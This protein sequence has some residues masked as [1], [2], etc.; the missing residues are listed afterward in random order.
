M[1]TK[2]KFKTIA[3]QNYPLNNSR[4]S[5]ENLYVYILFQTLLLLSN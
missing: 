3:Y 2:L 4:R 5:S 1:H